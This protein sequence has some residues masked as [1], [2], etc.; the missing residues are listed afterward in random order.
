MCERVWIKCVHVL[1]CKFI[2]MINECGKVQEERKACYIR[3]VMVSFLYLFN[4]NIDMDV[5][6]LF[7]NKRERE[8]S[9]MFQCSGDFGCCV[10]FFLISNCVI[11]PRVLIDILDVSGRR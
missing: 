1:F 5:C 6:F 3:E 7:L 4:I 8:A 2:E 11:I 10:F 9:L